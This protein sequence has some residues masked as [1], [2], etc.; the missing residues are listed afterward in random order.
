[1]LCKNNILFI[2]G[3]GSTPYI[4]IAMVFVLSPYIL[5]FSSYFH[6]IHNFTAQRMSKLSCM[7]ILAKYSFAILSM[8]FFFFFFFF[9]FFLLNSHNP[10][11]IVATNSLI[12]GCVLLTTSDSFT[13][14]YINP[15]I[16][17][18]SLFNTMISFCA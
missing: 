2:T 15:F 18:D 9:F 17:W 3:Y 4:G 1:M 11:T 10:I 16:T 13:N 8:L 6:M 7:S 12:P 5:K 14:C